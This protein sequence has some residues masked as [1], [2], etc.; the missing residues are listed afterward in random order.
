M[1][2]SLLFFALLS[3]CYCISSTENTALQL[4]IKQGEDFVPCSEIPQTTLINKGYSGTHLVGACAGGV[5]VTV[6]ALTLFSY[7]GYKQ[8]Q[9]DVTRAL[10]IVQAL[11]EGFG[12]GLQKVSQIK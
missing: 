5:A 9:P 11:S 2:K 8:I 3:S 12:Q 7:L 1:K 6:G 10:N 4:Y